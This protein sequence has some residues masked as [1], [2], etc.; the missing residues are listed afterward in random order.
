MTVDFDLTVFI[1]ETQLQH[2]LRA[3]DYT[4]YHH[5][6]TNRLATLRQQLNLSNDK[7]KFLKKE[8]TAHNATDPRHLMLVAL[9]AERCWASA[10]AMQEKR[11]AAKESRGEG[12]KPAGGVPPPD[13]Y[14][15]RLNKAAKFAA[16]LHHV[17]G[18]VAAPRLQQECNA[19]YMEAS[20]RAAASHGLFSEARKL[21]IAAREA[22]YGLRASSD[23]SQWA[24]VLLKV[25]ELDDRVVFC[26]QQ[27]G[28]DPASYRPP[29]AQG[30][31]PGTT[32]L[33]W[34]GRILNVTSIKVKDALREARNVPVESAAE[35]VL[36]V[37]GP[38]SMGQ[39]NRVLDLM[40]RRINYYNDA[41]AHAR[42]Q[43]RGAEEGAAKTER[44]LLVHYFLFQ[45]ADETLR[46][47]LFLAD[48]YSRRFHATEKVLQSSSSSSPSSPSSPGKGGAAKGK[49][50]ELTPA[51]FASP[52]EVVRLYAAA[53]DAVGEMELLPGV[54]GRDDVEEKA[55]VCRAG[56]LLY[57]G[58]GWR[59]TGDKAN[60]G[61]CYRA[62][63]HVLKDARDAVSKEL[64]ARAERRL[65]QVT[66]EALMSAETKASASVESVSYLSEASPGEVAVARNVARFPPD[67]QAVP[68][69]P[70]FVDIASTYVDFPMEEEETDAAP[71]A[72]SKAG[73]TAAPSQ[74]KQS[75][76]GPRPPSQAGGKGGAAGQQQQQQPGGG[77]KKWGWKWGW[78]GG[79]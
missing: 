49:K 44:Q 53:A 65:L 24:V 22:Y 46:R 69:K 48:V 7:K 51:Q 59:V 10:E 42:Q 11:Q 16:K 37:S 27:L 56:R 74:G 13:Q 36:E 76:S 29:L 8:V 35:K 33:S 38:V 61:Q 3:E 55:A 9:Y 32:T 60:A 73:S 63:L 5:Y 21:F 45:V 50:S 54:A 19:Y 17:A 47:T 6:L 75:A 70:T 25:N 77:D 52:A 78:G 26:M 15:K 20:G 62:A 39:A 23:D 67:Y 28:E 79:N 30:E 4:R 31:K 12:T 1:K 41:L 71:Q 58:E 57:T 64:Q 40:D 43:L 34:N 18:T 68:C 2:G 66:A 14:R 72:S